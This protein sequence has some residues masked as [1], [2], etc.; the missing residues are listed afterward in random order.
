M[1]VNI[2]ITVTF[3]SA[4]LLFLSIYRLVFHPL[5]KFPGPRAAALT[6]YYRAYYDVVRHG[7]WLDQLKVLHARYGPIIRVGPNEL[8]FST[9]D[10]YSEISR[11]PRDRHWY[12]GT[13][14]PTPEALITIANPQEASKRRGRYGPYFSRKA[15]LELESTVQYNV[16]KLIDKLSSYAT[17]TA[18]ADLLLAYRAATN[19]IITGYLFSQKFNAL[20]YER[21]EHPLLTGFDEIM[22]SVWILKY[23]LYDSKVF[24]MPRLPDWI[25]RMVNPAAQPVLDQKDFLV[26]KMKAWEADARMGKRGDSGERAIF[27]SFLKPDWLAKQRDGILDSAEGGQE[28]PWVAPRAVVIDEC[29]SIQFAGTDTVS[30]ACLIATFHL[31]NDRIML[32]K[33]RKELD[34]AWSDVED[35]ISYEKLEKLPYLTGV[36]KESLRLSHGAAGALPRVVNKSATVIAGCSVPFGT[37]VSSA[38][39]FVHMDPAIFPNPEKVIPERWIGPDSRALDKHLVAFSK[40]PRTCI[41]VNLAWCE[42]YLIMGNLF[43]KLDMEIYDTTAKDLEFGDFFIPLFRGKHLRAVV[44]GCRR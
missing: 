6:H 15:V 33:L 9:C 18:P 16:D 22:S 35:H 21:F 26:Q 36:I 37:A 20:D 27:D 2:A 5:A 41:G 25:V 12:K 13:L 44:K 42:L 30:N 14:C 40:G 10:A 8:H 1:L 28:Y 43:R 31:C 17:S 23:L 34:E 7:G 24:P 11:F 38:N 4:Y 19:D 32:E 29:T 3:F 39:Y